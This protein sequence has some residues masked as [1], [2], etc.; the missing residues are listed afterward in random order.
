MDF[1]SVGQQLIVLQQ[2]RVTEVIEVDLQ[3][4]YNAFFYSTYRIL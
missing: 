3:I 1:L 4:Y 2:F